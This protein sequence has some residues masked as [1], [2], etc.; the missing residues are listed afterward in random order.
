MFRRSS[1]A[2]MTVLLFLL[3]PLVNLLVGTRS[4]AVMGYQSFVAT[5]SEGR[6]TFRAQS[7]QL[8]VA[9][10]VSADGMM[11]TELSQAQRAAL[12]LPPPEE[13]GRL[14]KE[15]EDRRVL[16]EMVEV[17]GSIE[18]MDPITAFCYIV[19]V[20]G[21]ASLWLNVIAHLIHL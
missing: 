6:R 9:R 17:D 20:I 5:G 2:V 1:L 14:A 19:A 16:R 15:L 18:K 13:Q 11:E 21:V 12:R 4:S 10:P 3:L 8:H 7:A